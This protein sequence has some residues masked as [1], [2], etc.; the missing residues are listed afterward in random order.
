MEVII[1]IYRGSA[2][3]GSELVLGV[4]WCRKPVRPLI[5]QSLE[6]RI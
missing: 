1:G 6:F 2:G 5:L 4:H 3:A